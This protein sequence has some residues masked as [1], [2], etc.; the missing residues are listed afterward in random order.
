LLAEIDMLYEIF[1][2]SSLPQYSKDTVSERIVKMK[3]SLC[4]GDEDEN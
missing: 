3:K 4:H 2:N 1:I